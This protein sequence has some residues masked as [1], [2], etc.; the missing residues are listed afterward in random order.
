MRVL[1]VGAGGREHAIAT[2]I[3]ASS[4]DVEL[5]AVMGNRNPGIV[6]LCSGFL[7]AKETDLEKVNTYAAKIGAEIAIIGPEA[8]LGEGIVDLLEENG[9][10]CVAPSRDAS[11]IET[12]KAWARQFMVNHSIRGVPEFGVFDEKKSALN[13]IDELGDV[14]VKP[15][16]LTG[17]KGVRTM[18]DQLETLDDAKRYAA[19]LL[20]DN[21]RPVVIEENLKGEE[22]TIQAFVDGKNIRVSPAVQDHKRAYEGDLG[23]NTG[24]MGSYSCPDGLLPFITETDYE[25]GVSIM[26]DTVRAMCDEF[27]RGYRGILYGQF[28]LTSSG[29]KLIEFNARFGDPEAM[30]ILP[31]LETDFVDVMEG[32]VD[33]NLPDTTY[34]AMATVCKYVVPKGYPANPKKGTKLTVGDIGSAKLF[35]AS[36]NEVD[37]EI[38]T[39]TSRSIAVVGIAEDLVEAEQIAERGLS[40]ISGE[41]D[42]RHDIGTRDLIKK[43]VKRM[44]EI[45]SQKPSS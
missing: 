28:I 4:R 12:D 21:K 15:T 9:V 39:G 43:K 41:F 24:G 23:P 42:C 38:Y 35:Y 22:F 1:L 34:S 10:R 37:G 25:E 40:G 32:V 36:V 5:Y 19:K 13:F 27:D 7:I 29:V 14:A 31:L 20:E 11:Q 18:G 45:R 6:R 44:R 30:N 2:S 16:W 26:R 33:G 17:G 8:P 3:K